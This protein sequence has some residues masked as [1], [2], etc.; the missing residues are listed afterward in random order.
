M[1]V[2]DNFRREIGVGLSRQFPEVYSRIAKEK[3]CHFLNGA[4]YAKPCDEDGIHF[5]A[6][7]HVRLGNAVAEYVENVLED[8]LY[9]KLY[10]C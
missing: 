3:G 6:E 10:E 8:R 5:D 4:E 2:Y 9:G 7:S 1:D